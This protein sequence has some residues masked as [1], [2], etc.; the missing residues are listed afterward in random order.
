MELLFNSHHCVHTTHIYYAFFTHLLERVII[1]TTRLSNAGVEEHSIILTAKNIDWTC[2]HARKAKQCSFW[3]RL[4]W[5]F[6]SRN[7]S[8]SFV[9]SLCLS[10]KLIER[11]LDTIYCSVSAY[12]CCPETESQKKSLHCEIQFVSKHWWMMNQFKPQS[13][14]YFAFQRMAIRSRL[15][16]TFDSKN[17]MTSH[18]LR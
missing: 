14:R 9:A 1:N 12:V 2:A 5:A 7:T 3:A 4:S 10:K 18:L 11:K 13:C 6:R 17:V 16:L 8:T 15:H